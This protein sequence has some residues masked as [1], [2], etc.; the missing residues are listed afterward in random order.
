[1]CTVLQHPLSGEYWVPLSR[2]KAG[3]DAE[4]GAYFALKPDLIQASLLTPSGGFAFSA[5]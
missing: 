5:G 3:D 1:V 4:Y 2:A